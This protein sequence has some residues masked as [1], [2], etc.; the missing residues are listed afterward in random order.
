MKNLPQKNYFLMCA[1]QVISILTVL[2]IEIQIHR[3]NTDHP[4]LKLEFLKWNFGTTFYWGTGLVH[5][6]E[7]WDMEIC[8][9]LPGDESFCT[10]AKSWRSRATPLNWIPE[11]AE[12]TDYHYR[13]PVQ[14]I[15]RCWVV[16]RWCKSSETMKRHGGAQLWP[17]G[18]SFL[19]S[20]FFFFWLK[21]HFIYKN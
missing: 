19:V 9:S 10:L 18:C 12:A 8:T 7:S 6:L 20:V 15:L 11:T 16:R 4:I 3:E 13:K 21:V 1:R 5:T 17:T 2:C 14:H